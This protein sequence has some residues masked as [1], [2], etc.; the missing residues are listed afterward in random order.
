M[1]SPLSLAAPTMVRLSLS[2]QPLL[3]IGCSHLQYFL[4]SMTHASTSFF[5]SNLGTSETFILSEESFAGKTNGVGLLSRGVMLG[6][7]A[8]VREVASGVR[9]GV[10]LKVACSPIVLP[11]FVPR[12]V[13]VL[14][15]LLISW[16]N[17]IIVA[18][19]GCSM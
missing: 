15:T 4:N 19:L 3:P 17:Y 6:D 8:G 12:V 11:F 1:L 2:L 18:T 7:A 14:P 10:L 16:R 9:P 13:P 5:P